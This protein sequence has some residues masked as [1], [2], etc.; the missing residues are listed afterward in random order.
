MSTL[1]CILFLLSAK[2]RRLGA[3]ELASELTA[4]AGEIHCLDVGDSV[5]PEIQRMNTRWLKESESPGD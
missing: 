2:A 1:E 4:L 5:T 3:A